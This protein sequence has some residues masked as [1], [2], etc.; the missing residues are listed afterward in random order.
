[1]P[2]ATLSL[3]VRRA[4]TNADLR[5]LLKNL[6]NQIRSNAPEVFSPL[7]GDFRRLSGLLDNLESL[8]KRGELKYAFA[9]VKIG[10]EAAGMTTVMAFQKLPVKRDAL[11]KLE[12]GGY[13]K[14][15]AKVKAQIAELE[16]NIDR[17]IERYGTIFDEL[18]ELDDDVVRKSF[19][20]YIGWVRRQGP[21][22][23]RQLK[24]AKLMQRHFQTYLQTRRW[25][26]ATWRSALKNLSKSP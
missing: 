24:S 18:G 10:V 7:K 8:S 16:S 6:E 5:G 11:K 9:L 12:K 14:L 2:G 13:S 17:G 21:K 23:G 1:M 25:D 26:G 22:Y 20:D 15:V 19:G 3:N 4:A